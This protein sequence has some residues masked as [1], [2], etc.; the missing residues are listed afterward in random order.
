MFY[1]IFFFSKNKSTEVSKLIPLTIDA[2]NLCAIDFNP[3]DLG[4][5]ASK[6]ETYL[7]DLTRENVQ[8][9]VNKIF[10]ELPTRLEEDGMCAV[11]PKCTIP[12]PREKPLP[13]PKPK[14]KWETFADK[15]GIKK[16]KKSLKSFD[17]ST[18]EYLPTHGYKSAVNADLKDWMVEVPR[19]ADPFEDHFAKK[20]EAKKSNQGAIQK[21]QQKN[22][23][24]AKGHK[25][26][27][28]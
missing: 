15:K 13:K 25:L 7:K 27:K 6:K 26:N 4:A 2:G 10:G 21:K 22:L 20:K 23:N 1:L 12:I 18:G 5:Y 16:T 11:L 17:E 19:G 28:K 3:L 9:L 8:L 14:T 24:R